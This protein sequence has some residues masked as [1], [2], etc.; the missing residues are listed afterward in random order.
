MLAFLQYILTHLHRLLEVLV[1]VLEDLLKCLL[2]KLNHLLL[3]IE[4]L[5][6][7]LS[8]LEGPIFIDVNRLGW[9]GKGRHLHLCHLVHLG[10]F[11]IKVASLGFWHLDLSGWLETLKWI[12]LCK[13]ID[14]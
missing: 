12:C 9:L 2:I 5:A 6:G 11:E 13:Q 8:L 7:L 10:H 4:H 1:S 3:I 14:I